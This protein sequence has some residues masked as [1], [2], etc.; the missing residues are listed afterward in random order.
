MKTLWGKYLL[1]AFIFLGVVWPGRAVSGI[2]VAWG[3][4]SHGID[5]EIIGKRHEVQFR[6]AANQLQSLLCAA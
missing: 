4:N 5:N 1:P 3:E 2:V 6:T